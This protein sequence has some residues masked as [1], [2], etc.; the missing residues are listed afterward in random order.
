MLNVD[1]S[2]ELRNPLAKAVACASVKSGVVVP[3]VTDKGAFAVTSVTV[4][5]APEY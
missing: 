1:Q 4:P 3:L 5:L 2:V